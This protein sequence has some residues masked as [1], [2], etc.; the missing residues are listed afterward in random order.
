MSLQELIC[1][2]ITCGIVY[3]LKDRIYS[4]ILNS[5]TP[6]NRRNIGILFFISL[7]VVSIGKLPGFSHEFITLGIVTPPI[8][9]MLRESYNED[10]LFFWGLLFFFSGLLHEGLVR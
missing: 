7:M 10:R 5:P 2:L 3:F 4:P 8:I 6:L 1:Y 9:K